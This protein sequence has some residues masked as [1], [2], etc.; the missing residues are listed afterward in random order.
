[1]VKL[2]TIKQHKLWLNDKIKNQQSFIK[3]TKGKKWEIKK[4]RIKLKK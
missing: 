2:K 1:M 4:I 3:K